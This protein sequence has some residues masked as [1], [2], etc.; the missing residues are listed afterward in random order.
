MVGAPLFAAKAALRCGVGLVTV[1]LPEGLATAAAGHSLE[2]MI[3]PLPQTIEGCL[4]LASIAKIKAILSN[5]DVLLIGPGLSRATSTQELIRKVIMECR[6]KTIID[7]DG[8]NAW[9]GHLDNFKSQVSCLPVDKNTM[10]IITP[11]PGEMA[12][13]LASST[14]EV[15]RKRQTVA[16]T[17]SK[18]YNVITVLKGY[19]TVTAHP[20]GRT[21]INKTGNS[22]MSTAGSGDVLAGIIAALWAQGL[23][24]F[25]AARYGVFLHGAAGDLA[26]KNKTQLG[27]IA[28][29][30]IEYIPEALKKAKQ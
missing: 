8:L 18:V 9:V 6:I 30:I 7:A 29:D 1:G 17:F 27:L 13:L 16:K 11:H 23:N 20:S 28:S 24:S 25:D 2:S 15:Q 22:G 21:F 4:S 10:R 26:A 14:A 12:R 3:A 5:T 19:Q